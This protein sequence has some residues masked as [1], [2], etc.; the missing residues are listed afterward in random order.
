MIKT[1][2]RCLVR[3]SIIFI[4]TMNTI[5]VPQLMYPLPPW[6]CI[7]TQIISAHLA[8]GV[9]GR[10]PFSVVAGPLP[11]T[12]DAHL[13]RQQYCSSARQRLIPGSGLWGDENKM[14]TAV[15]VRRYG[16]PTVGPYL[17]MMY[18]SEGSKLHVILFSWKQ[19]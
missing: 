2:S 9:G 13:H 14:S 4:T 16:T 6:L 11:G 3:G 18:F 17:G 5:Y 19:R 15:V 12:G 10:P 1:A 8:S 7:L